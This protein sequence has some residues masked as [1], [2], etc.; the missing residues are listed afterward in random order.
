M[1]I[2][3]IDAFLA[4]EPSRGADEPA[5]G[6]FTTYDDAALDIKFLM[7]LQQQGLGKVCVPNFSLCGST[8]TGGVT[9]PTRGCASHETRVAAG[10]VVTRA[11]SARPRLVAPDDLCKLVGECRARFVVLNLG[12]YRQGFATTGHAN[13]LLFDTRT[14]TMERFEPTGGVDRYAPLFERL[15]GWRY[16]THG[17]TSLQRHGT[18]AFQGLCAT[19]SLAYVL[20]R[21]RN[22]DVPPGA[23]VRHMHRKP[24]GVL[25]DEMLRLNRFA[26]DTLR[27]LPRGSL[28]RPGRRP[29]RRKPSRSR[30]KA[31]RRSRPRKS[32]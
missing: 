22:P 8:S 9:F 5:G 29:S 1:R 23:I 31:S 20:Y 4:D 27:R 3:E 17:A 25:R 24:P 21:V 13:A 16:V 28:A 7:A 26:A 15:C 12:V 30:R 32:S 2:V 14:R 11:A 6:E 18:D 19:Y 10:L